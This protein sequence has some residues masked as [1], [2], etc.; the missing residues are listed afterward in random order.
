MRWD[1]EEEEHSAE[2]FGHFFL[3][4]AVSP[5]QCFLYTASS[6]L[7]S[8]L[9][10]SLLPPPPSRGR[11]G[12]LILWREIRLFSP[13]F[14]FQR[15]GFAQKLLPKVVPGGRHP[16]E[17]VWKG[18][19]HSPAESAYNKPKS[20]ASWVF[21]GGGEGSSENCW[22]WQTQSGRGRDFLLSVSVL[23]QSAAAAVLS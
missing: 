9:T 7:F 19:G 11:K 10:P 2:V 13:F 18:W 5:P 22:R 17:E 16:E 8:S 6:F 20:E 15:L 1:E 12:I 23:V 4:F 21:G 14:L 3:M